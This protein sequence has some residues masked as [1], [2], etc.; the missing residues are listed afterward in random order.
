MHSKLRNAN[1]NRVFEFSDE[2]REGFSMLS[3]WGYEAGELYDSY[4]GDG[5]AVY[6]MVNARHFEFRGRYRLFVDKGL[7]NEHDCRSSIIYE[8][9]CDNYFPIKMNGDRYN[10]VFAK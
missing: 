3:N 2:E 8:Y 7:I 9:R 5:P 6:Y 10:K 1:H 4:Q